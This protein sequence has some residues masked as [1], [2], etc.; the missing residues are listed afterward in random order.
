MNN[1]HNLSLCAKPEWIGRADCKHC[2]IRQM[3][4]FSSLD[5]SDFDQVLEPIDNLRFG[6]KACIYTQGEESNSI[7]SIRNGLVKL[8][9]SLPDGT[10]RIVRLLGPGAV[11]GLE[12]LVGET[13]HH[14]LLVCQE[15]DICR[16]PVETMMQ[17]EKEHPKFNEQVMK[18]WE[19]HLNL[20][21][22][23]IIELSSGPIRN[24]VIRFL[25][26]LLEIRSVKNNTVRL[27]SY[28]D[29]AAIIDTSRE[30]FNRIIADLKANGVVKKG[31]SPKELEC[32]VEG[33]KSLL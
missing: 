8:I 11:T 30:T 6:P 2:A 16:I 10:Q 26:M 21:D 27:L 12:A 32:D 1:E 13:Y 20:A 29:M 28:D 25:L 23:W 9:Q 24:R 5:A 33:L 18:H 22:R 17:L 3:M 4:L 7:Y 19:Q 15:V 31:E 14:T